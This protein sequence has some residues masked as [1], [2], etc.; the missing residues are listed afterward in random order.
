MQIISIWWLI[1]NT[2]GTLTTF[3]RR[4]K[5]DKDLLDQG[6]RFCVVSFFGAEKSRLQDM[7]FRNFLS[8]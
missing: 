3:F 8:I 4:F 1:S 5:R 7:M 6:N 2:P